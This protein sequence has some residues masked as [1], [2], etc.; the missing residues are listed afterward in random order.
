MKNISGNVLPNLLFIAYCYTPLAAD[1]G[2][3]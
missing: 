2:L 3:Q 1:E